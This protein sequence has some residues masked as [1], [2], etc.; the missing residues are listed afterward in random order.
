MPTTRSAR[1]N[2]DGPKLES[3]LGKDED[4]TSFKKVSIDHVVREGVFALENLNLKIF[5]LDTKAVAR[6]TL[7]VLESQT[8]PKLT[9]DNYYN[10]KVNM[11]M[12]LI[13]KD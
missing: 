13:G 5:F 10:W 8:F 3:F 11:L 7:D 1:R 2:R 6:K 12:S 9:N 4:P